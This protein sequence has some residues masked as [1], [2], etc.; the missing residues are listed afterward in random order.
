MLVSKTILT[1]PSE[2]DFE[3]GVV[4]L[5]DKPIGWTSFDV[6]AK[7]RNTL[8]I[9]KVGH[10]GT[11]DP[12]ATGLLILC[13]GKK[14]KIIDSIQDSTKEYIAEIRLGATTPSY[15]AEFPPENHQSIEGISQTQ[16]ANVLSSFVGLIEQMPPAYSAV[17]VKG[18]RAYDL[19]RSGKSPALTPRPVKIDAI[20][21]LDYSDEGILNL[22]VICH[23]G[24]YIRS[25]AHDVG[26]KLGC[27]AYLNALCRTQIGAYE[28]SQ[29][30]KIEDFVAKFKPIP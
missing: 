10:A 3:A 7:V 17:K 21:L 25:L 24:T 2:Y 1:N 26:Q 12:L 18:K 13:T 4:L 8:K 22:K 9:K 6:V 14:T 23:K 19:A 20:E 30:L 16:I 28:L 15:D 29:A 27:G 5:I 11:L